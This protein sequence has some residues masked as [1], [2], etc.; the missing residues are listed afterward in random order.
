MTKKKKV[1]IQT[2]IEFDSKS[3]FIQLFI[4]QLSG[5]INDAC[6]Q[7]E[8]FFHCDDCGN[9]HNDILIQCKTLKNVGRDQ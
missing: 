7:P 3:Q 6:T 2:E 1:M 9:D 5:I 8:K 4:Q